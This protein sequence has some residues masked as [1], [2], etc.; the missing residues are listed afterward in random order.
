MTGCQQHTLTVNGVE[1]CWF[2]WHPERRLEGTILLVHATG[3]H[4]RCWDQTIAHLGERHIIALDMRG[5]GRSGKVAPFTWQVFGADL[6]AFI[7]HLDL[8]QIVGAGHSMGGHSLTQTVAAEQDR[9]ERIVLVDPVILSP[10][11]YSQYVGQ[12]AAEHPV[13]RRRNQFDSPESLYANLEGRGS[14]AV[15]QAEVLRDYSEYGLLP[16]PEGEGYVLACPPIIEASI[17]TGSA[18]TNIH[19]LLATITLPVTVLRAMQRD[20][21]HTLMD[22]S[23]S[24]TWPALAGEFA[25]GVDVYLPMHSHF[26]PMEV[27]GLVADYILKYPLAN[28]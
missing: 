22:F 7:R 19:A 15:W 28:Q 8:N 14:F 27:P 11:A 13:S 20:P 9:F 6:T 3:F 25:N 26:L 10:E 21:G 1:L 12:S 24:P 18:G 16:S 2:E 5:H 4:A 23:K 17:Y